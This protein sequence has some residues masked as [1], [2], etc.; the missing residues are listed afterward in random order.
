ME[1]NE[2]DQKGLKKKTERFLFSSKTGRRN[3]SRER[4]GKNSDILPVAVH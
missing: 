3:R 2:G 4:E 1:E